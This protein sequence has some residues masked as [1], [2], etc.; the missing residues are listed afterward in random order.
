M[1]QTNDSFVLKIVRPNCCVQSSLLGVVNKNRYFKIKLIIEE[2]HKMSSD[3]DPK[4]VLQLIN[5]MGYKN[6]SAQELKGFTKGKLQRLKLQITFVSYHFE[7]CIFRFEKTG[8][9]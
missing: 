7:K 4:R 9:I 2:N 8:K 6:V 1:E 3:V 5:S